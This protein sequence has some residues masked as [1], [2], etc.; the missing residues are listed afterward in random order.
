[1]A[2]NFGGGGG[3]GGDIF[4][5]LSQIMSSELIFMTLNFM[6]ATQSRGVALH[7]Q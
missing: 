5:L 7:K 1:M 4:L 6:T 3:G 2:D